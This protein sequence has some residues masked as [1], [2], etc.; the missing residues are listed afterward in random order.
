M[1]K[2]RTR[3]K[4]SSQ[5]VFT[6]AS[7]V[8]VMVGNQWFTVKPGSWLVDLRGPFLHASWTDDGREPIHYAAF[9]SKVQM[10]RKARER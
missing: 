1:K 4:K 7:V 10:V 6:D 3:A 2:K 8:S 9:I 5:K